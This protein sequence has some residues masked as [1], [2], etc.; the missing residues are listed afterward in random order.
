MA[1]FADAK[2]RA[3]EV[4]ISVGSIR[5][6]RDRLKIDLSKLIDDDFAVLTQVTADLVTLCDVLY[7]LVEPQATPAGVS[8]VEFGESLDGDSLERGAD[9][10]YE[11]FATFSHSRIREPLLTLAQKGREVRAAATER[12]EAAG[13]ALAAYSTTATG[14][15]ASSASTPTD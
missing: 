5:R 13:A 6:V 1:K 2:G 8:D 11:A 12:M 14:S 4:L 3:W 10:L 7:V 15:P 9:A